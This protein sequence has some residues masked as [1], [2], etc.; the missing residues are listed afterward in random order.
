MNESVE[1]KFE[2]LLKV[3]GLISE[4]ASEKFVD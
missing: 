4:I 1:K 2:V 3:F